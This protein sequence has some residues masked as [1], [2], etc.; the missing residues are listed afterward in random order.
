MKTLLDQ[1]N[2]AQIE[3][4][5]QRYHPLLEL[6]R[7]KA[8]I[9]AIV[10]D[11]DEQLRISRM[12]QLQKLMVQMTKEQIQHFINL[13]PPNTSESVSY[14]FTKLILHF[15]PHFTATGKKLEGDDATVMQKNVDLWELK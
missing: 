14:L 10:L 13:F 12:T 15:L 6:Y 11:I 7:Q 9:S 8:V 1:D 5:F 3:V 2:I 4:L